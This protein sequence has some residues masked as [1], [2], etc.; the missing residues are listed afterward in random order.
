MLLMGN[1]CSLNKLT[2]AS[3]AAPVGATATFTVQAGG[4]IANLADTGLTCS[5][6]GS[7][8]TCTSTGTNAANTVTAGQFID[9]KVVL[10]NANTPNPFFVYWAIGCQ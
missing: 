6:S 9:I 4:T 8:Q 2:V 10:A 1:S 3:S 7:T 5:L